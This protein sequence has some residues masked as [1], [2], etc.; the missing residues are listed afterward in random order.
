MKKRAK[1]I[2]I[3]VFSL[4]VLSMFLSN[5]NFATTSS[6]IFPRASLTPTPPFPKTPNATVSPTVQQSQ[7]MMPKMTPTMPAAN[8]TPLTTAS[9]SVNKDLRTL[10]SGKG[11]VRFDHDSHAFIPSYSEDGK[12]PAGCVVCHHTD[13]PPERSEPLTFAVW[14]GSEVKNCKDCHFP[15]SDIP[16]GKEML[17]FKGKDYNDER[18]YHENCTVCHAQ[19]A[20]RAGFKAKSGFVTKI[21]GEC[22]SCHK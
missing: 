5:R 21:P 19:A 17:V 12:S 7:T 2:V 20:L 8:S 16:E 6:I 4:G 10:E 22:G 15:L 3:L 18:A 1:L 9:P 13:K 14:K 11:D